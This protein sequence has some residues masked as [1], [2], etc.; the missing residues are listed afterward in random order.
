MDY[1]GYDGG[2]TIG[3]AAQYSK[4]R[5]ISDIPDAE[6]FKQAQK[7]TRPLSPRAYLD[8]LVPHTAQD[9]TIKGDDPVRGPRER[10]ATRISNAPAALAVELAGVYKSE[11]ITDSWNLAVKLNRF[12]PSSLSKDF[13]AFDPSSP[14]QV[15]DMIAY[16]QERRPESCASELERTISLQALN[17]SKAAD[18]TRPEVRAAQ[19]RAQTNKPN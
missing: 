12:R 6:L 19:V 7:L 17:S 18:L 16:A 9:L 4:I 5:H 15:R 8:Y 1:F 2:Q 3:T 14:Q 10:W 11:Y 13:L